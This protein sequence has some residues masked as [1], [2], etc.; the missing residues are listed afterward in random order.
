[1]D[2]KKDNKEV[3]QTEEKVNYKLTI[4][5]RNVPEIEKVTAKILAQSE[6]KNKEVN[7]SVTIKGPVRMPT[8]VLKITTRKGP[9]GNGAYLLL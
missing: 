2:P 8:K 3:E 9:C 1:M 7:A 6:A 4:T 5:H